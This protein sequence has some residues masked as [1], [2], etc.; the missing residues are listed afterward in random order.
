MLDVVR[1]YG[2]PGE[3]TCCE[4]WCRFEFSLRTVS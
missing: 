4:Q 2:Q 1:W 3:I